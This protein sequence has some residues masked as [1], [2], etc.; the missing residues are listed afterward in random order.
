MDKLT[1][2]PGVAYLCIGTTQQVLFHLDLPYTIL[3][4]PTTEE[5]ILYC[6]GNAID[7]IT[8]DSRIL[9]IF[10][11]ELKIY[12][13]FKKGEGTHYEL[14][15]HMYIS[16]SLYVFIICTNL[17]G[18]VTQK[19]AVKRI[20][21]G[22]YKKIDLRTFN[23]GVPIEYNSYPHSYKVKAE[24]NQL[25][26][27]DSY[28]EHRDLILC[29]RT[30]EGISIW[31][32]FSKSQVFKY[33]L[34]PN[35]K[36]IPLVSYSQAYALQPYLEPFVEK[37]DEWGS[38]RTLNT[39]AWWV[40]CSCN[41]WAEKYNTGLSVYTNKKG[42]EQIGFRPSKKATEYWWNWLNETYQTVE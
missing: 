17:L 8:G 9:F 32:N 29:L 40:Y 27:L 11:Q 2:Q 35:F 42:E 38:F 3:E 41:Y 25:G 31:S 22:V 24:F 10:P 37:L 23:Y 1:F 26:D 39:F 13:E 6:K 12:K 14:P 21:G 18:E 19:A 20:E 33:F 4:S 28:K 5:I 34:I 7:E 30:L 15:E 16:D 36:H